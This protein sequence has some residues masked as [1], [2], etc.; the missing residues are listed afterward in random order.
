MGPV[1]EVKLTNY[2]ERY[3]IEVE[4]NSMPND[5]TQS[6]IVINRGIKKYVTELPDENEKFTHC[7]EVPSS[8]GKPVATKQKEL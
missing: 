5:R 3:G 2:V 4:I 7:E 8:S 1:L 6:W